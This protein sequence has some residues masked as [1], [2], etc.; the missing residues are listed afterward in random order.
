MQKRYLHDFFVPA[1]STVPSSTSIQP[2]GISNG[3]LRKE[4]RALREMDRGE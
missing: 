1:I 4:G 3:N 2:P